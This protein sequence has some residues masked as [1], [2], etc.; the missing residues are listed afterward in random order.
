MSKI[1]EYNITTVKYK[2]QEYLF[3]LF[4]HSKDNQDFQARLQSKKDNE[5]FLISDIENLEFEHDFV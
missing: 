3:F 5:R 2:W 4:Q 1:R